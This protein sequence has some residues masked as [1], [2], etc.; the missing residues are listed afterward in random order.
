MEGLAVA[1]RRGIARVAGQ[2]LGKH[3]LTSVLTLVAVQAGEY[4]GEV[5]LF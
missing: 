4:T 3:L 2:D 1:L 5:G